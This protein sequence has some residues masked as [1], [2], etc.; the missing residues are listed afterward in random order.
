MSAPMPDPDL[1]TEKRCSACNGRGYF[2]CACWPGDCICGQDD[3]GC[4]NC[5]GTGFL[6]PAYPEED[7]A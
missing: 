2:R 3:E 6:D 1:P 7:D 4:E 5:G